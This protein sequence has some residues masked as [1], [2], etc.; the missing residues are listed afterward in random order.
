MPGH[1]IPVLTSTTILYFVL[2]LEQDLNHYLF[3]GMIYVYFSRGLPAS[4]LCWIYD[5]T[6][7]RNFM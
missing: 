7:Y 4:R 1:L 3:F 2:N 6:Y 5:G